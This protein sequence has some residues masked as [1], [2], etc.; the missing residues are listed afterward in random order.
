MQHLRRQDQPLPCVPCADHDA[1][2]HLPLNAD[3]KKLKK[4]SWPIFEVTD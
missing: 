4:K 1:H 2:T 3:V